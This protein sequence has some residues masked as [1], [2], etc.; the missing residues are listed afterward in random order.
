MKYKNK[1]IS[2]GIWSENYLKLAKWYE[3]VLKIPVRQKS[4][5]PNDS[6]VAFDFGENWFWIGKHDKVYAKN[7]DPYRIMVEFYIERVSKAFEEL[8]EKSVTIIAKPFQDPTDKNSW[9]MTIQDPED[10]IIQ[11]YGGK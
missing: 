3:D 10:N 2:V 5:L 9:C 8:Q 11:L 1:A 6:Y 4:E 7:R